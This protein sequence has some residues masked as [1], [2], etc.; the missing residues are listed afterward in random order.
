MIG[1]LLRLRATELRNRLRTAP[2]VLPVGLGAAVLVGA[3]LYL[4]GRAVA[5]GDGDPA[6]AAARA[7]ERTFWVNAALGFLLAYTSF[8]A[9]YRSPAS[10]RLEAFPVAPSALFVVRL[11]GLLAAHLPLLVAA[12]LFQAP[13]LDAGPGLFAHAAVVHG[14]TWMFG[15][16]AG[17]WLHLLAG[18]SL[19]SGESWLKEW[20]G[21]GYRT[22][23]A[24]LLLYSPGVTLAAA[25][26]AAVPLELAA[27]SWPLGG[28]PRPAFV[29]LGLLGLLSL[30]AVL[31]AARVHAVSW[32]FIRARFTEAEVLPP[33]R[34]GELP[35]RMAGAVLLR[36]LRPPLAGLYRK[37]LAQLRRRHRVDL[38]LVVAVL[39]G[40]TLFHL[41][42]TL[43]AGALLAWDAVLLVLFAGVALTPAYKLVGRELEPDGTD[44]LLPI[45]PGLAR[46]AKALVALTHQAPLVAGVAL[47]YGIASRDPVGAAVLLFGGLAGSVALS[48]LF[49]R[50]ALSRRRRGAWLGW[51]FRGSVAALALL[52]AG[53][54]G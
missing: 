38:A 35:R 19:L 5:A 18:R 41:R 52:V 29:F 1:T 30:A 54:L 51:A 43:S 40:M 34:E 37:D 24:A 27:R 7:F 10:L 17:L 39:V 45:A 9:L 23:E 31:H 46:R 2:W 20:L 36:W 48:L 21:S 25:L 28:E 26:G 44:A 11:L 42:T 4:A 14:G 22:N 49:L 47:L 8:E 50:L 16:C 53:V 32:P 3:G 15:L 6:A 13:L 12:L 33:W